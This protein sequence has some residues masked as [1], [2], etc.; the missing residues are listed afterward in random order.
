MWWNRIARWIDMPLVAALHVYLFITWI[1]NKRMLA[2][3]SVISSSAAQVN[4]S[5]H[6]AFLTAVPAQVDYASVPNTTF[7]AQQHDN[8][9]ILKLRLV[10]MMMKLTLH[11]I[12][13]TTVMMMLMLKFI[14]MTIMA[15]MRIRLRKKEMTMIMQN[16][17]MRIRMLMI[18]M[19]TP[20]QPLRHRWSIK[21]MRVDTELRSVRGVRV[22]SA[23]N[24]LVLSGHSNS[25]RTHRTK[26]P[27]EL[28]SPK[29]WLI[30]PIKKLIGSYDSFQK[31][32]GSY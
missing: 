2:W 30:G 32:L 14:M 5:G 26:P 3:L 18:M 19:K 25:S 22:G 15:M 21:R 20:I 10:R 4:W 6:I 16:T 11:I 12:V 9:V 24:V 7:N 13:T 29:G 23:N 8:N 31:L 1:M 17:T 28:L 27:P